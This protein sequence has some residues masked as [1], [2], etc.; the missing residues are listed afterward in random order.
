MELD[1]VRRGREGPEERLRD[2]HSAQSGAD[3][4]VV[5]APPGAVAG[6]GDPSAPSVTPAGAPAAGADPVGRSPQEDGAGM[7][8]GASSAPEISPTSQ[9]ADV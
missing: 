1:S 6:G 8:A 4:S 2:D 7:T 3:V 9:L 5:P